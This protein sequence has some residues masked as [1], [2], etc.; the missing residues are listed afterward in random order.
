MEKEI[1]DLILEYEKDFFDKNF[2]DNRSNLEERLAPNFIEYG[3][4]GKTYDRGN[5]I[6]ALCDLPQNRQIEITNFKVSQLS[7]DALLA[8]YISHDL[9]DDAYALRTSIWKYEDGKWKLYFH[10]GTPKQ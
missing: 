8:R 4:S 9:K 10:Q 1:T 7:C 3:K 2:C 6:K 5:A